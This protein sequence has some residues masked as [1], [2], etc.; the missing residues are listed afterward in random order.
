MSW[1]RAVLHRNADD[2]LHLT[3]QTV[4]RGDKPT[5]VV[6]G[7]VGVSLAAGFQVG[8]TIL[9]VNGQ[10][11]TSVAQVTEQVTTVSTSEDI[12]FLL[13][14]KPYVAVD[15]KPDL[16]A[17]TDYCDIFCLSWWWRARTINCEGA[18]TQMRMFAM[19]TVLATLS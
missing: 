1:H 14:R 17:C 18:I 3:M 10:P 5:V 7:L 2:P 8:D 13:L 9:S 16:F 4:L 6:T 15:F 19:C 12:M 11:V